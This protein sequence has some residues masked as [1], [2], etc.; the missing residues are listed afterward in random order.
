MYKQNIIAKH[1]M[2]NGIVVIVREGLNEKKRWELRLEIPK[3][4]HALWTQDN[5]VYEKRGTLY[6]AEDK[7]TGRVRYFH[8]ATPGYGFGGQSYQLPMVDGST[9][10]LIG[11]WSSRTECTNKAGFL[12][13]KEVTIQAMYNMADNLSVEAINQLLAPLDMECVVIDNNAYI[14]RL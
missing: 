14:I 13:S 10:T 8:Y 9:T 11:P 2:N 6:F 3:H 7:D 4:L 12:P 5:F 1:V